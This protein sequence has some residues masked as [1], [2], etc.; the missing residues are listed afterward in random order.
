MKKT[1]IAW[2]L[3]VVIS[4]CFMTFGH[5]LDNYYPPHTLHMKLNIS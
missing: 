4:L 1:L 2:L 5:V 3:L